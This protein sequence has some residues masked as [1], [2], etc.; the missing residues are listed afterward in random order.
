MYQFGD[1]CV[2]LRR[3]VVTRE[4]AQVELEPKAFDVLR[5][6]LENADRLVSKDELME[7]VWT[8]S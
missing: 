7:T 4:G 8:R 6:L 2:D 3:L 1:V 5:Y